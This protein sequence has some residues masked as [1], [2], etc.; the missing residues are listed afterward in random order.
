MWSSLFSAGDEEN[1][2]VVR[3]MS[4]P[5]NEIPVALPINAVV[6][7]TDEVAFALLGLQVYSTGVS[8]D[9]AVRA[10]TGTENNELNEI[11]F[12]HGPPRAGRMM[13][14]VE[15]ADGRRASNV[16]AGH[17]GGD[18]VFHGGGGGGGNRSVDQSWWLSP[19]PPEGP[20]TFVVRCGALGI[21]ETRTVLDGAQINRAAAD[22]VVLWPWQP[23]TAH[24]SERPP[25]PPDVPDDS[26]FTPGT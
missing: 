26:W 16:H 1:E 7:R 6:A 11:V 4:A 23:P 25:P 17:A 18:V 9:L 13:L 22:V 10:R 15:L 2:D 14:G 12:E 24:W 8:F 5:D 20:L 19:L 21:E 3:R